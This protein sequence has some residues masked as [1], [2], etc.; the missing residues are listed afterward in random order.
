MKNR[1]M[2]TKCKSLPFSFFLL[3]Q[4]IKCK[5]SEINESIPYI[6]GRMKEGF[7]IK[8]W[9]GSKMMMVNRFLPA[10][11]KPQLQFYLGDCL[12]S[13]EEK[14]K[15]DSQTKEGSFLLKEKGDTFLLLLFLL[16]LICFGGRQM[17]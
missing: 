7:L 5:Q 3:C 8:R 9:Q 10:K 11:S 17:E 1:G 2:A 4:M 16:M 15:V 12:V 6:R 14:V 13:E